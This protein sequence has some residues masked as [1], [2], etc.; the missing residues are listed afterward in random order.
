M[1]RLMQVY[2]Y[3]MILIVKNWYI[4]MFGFLFPLAMSFLIS[5]QEGAGLPASAQIQVNTSIVLLFFNIIPLSSTYIGYA[6]IFSNE[7][8]HEIPLRMELFAV[9]Q[10]QTI[11][12]RAL[13][14]LTFNIVSSVVYFVIEGV[15]L[16]MTRPHAGGI[17]VI[18][19]IMIVMNVLLFLLAH[20][21]CLIFRGFSKTYA[22]VMSSYFAMMFL[23]GMMG[24][25]PEQLPGAAN[26]IS[27]LIPFS[28]AIEVFPKLWAGAAVNIMPLIQSM[29]FF[30]MLSCIILAGALAKIRRGKPAA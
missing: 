17:A 27:R 5:R 16:G 14:Y 19:L 20:A 28:Y 12:A 2:R 21:L 29:L 9:S 22:V 15:F 1:R 13:G 4:L 30:G 6:A 3:N 26:M 11:G 18:V 25:E 10:K 8:E 7:I 24:I 23:S